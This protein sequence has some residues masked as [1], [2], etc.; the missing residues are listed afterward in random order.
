MPYRHK[1]GS[2]FYR[3]TRE[4]L[5][6]NW[7]LLKNTSNSSCFVRM[8]EMLTEIHL[9]LT[10]ILSFKILIP[11][12]RTYMEIKYDST[13]QYLLNIITIFFWLF[14]PFLFF[15]LL[16][17]IFSLKPTLFSTQILFL[18]S[19]IFQLNHFK[20]MICF[21]SSMFFLFGKVSKLNSFFHI[22][23]TLDFYP[24]FQQKRY[25]LLLTAELFFFIELS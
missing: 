16:V 10:G 25:K 24:F 8:Y 2:L 7:K 20:L 18:L 4:K 14:L 3:F 23:R 19:L 21:F 11:L 12:S 1:M 17:P 15:Y 13:M 6:M 22:F 9:N 5:I